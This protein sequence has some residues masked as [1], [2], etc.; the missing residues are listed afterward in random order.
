MYP[1]VRKVRTIGR[2]AAS[3]RR[4]V[5]AT[6]GLTAVV[7]LTLSLLPFRT[8]KGWTEA[9]SGLRGSRVLR[10]LVGKTWREVNASQIAWAV[11]IASR[12]V[13]VASCL[14]QALT[15][16]FLLNAAGIDNEIHIGVTLQEETGA[17]KGE[18]GAHAWVEQGGVV[19]VGGSEQ[20][21]RYARILTLRP[22]VA[23]RQIQ[24]Y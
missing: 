9:A 11:K 23:K 7:R 21:L 13:P 17:R 19:L 24:R 2:L 3:D 6:I 10:V 15:A 4:L 12:Y 20:S 16:Q 22:R 5:A 14:T 18:F 8:I 1:L